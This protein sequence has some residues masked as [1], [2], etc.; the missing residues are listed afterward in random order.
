M[1]ILLELESRLTVISLRSL[2]IAQGPLPQI[3][4]SQFGSFVLDTDIWL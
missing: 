3:S 2:I 1:K 4:R